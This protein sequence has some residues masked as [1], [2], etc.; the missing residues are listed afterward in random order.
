MQLEIMYADVIFSNI[1][2]DYFENIAFRRT[3][4][5]ESLRDILI[6]SK[7]W[8]AFIRPSAVGGGRNDR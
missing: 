3:R 2:I 5:S 8:M 7:G 1:N 6:L 4:I